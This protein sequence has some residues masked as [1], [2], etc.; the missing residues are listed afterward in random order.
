M[1]AVKMLSL[2]DAAAM[3]ELH[4]IAFPASEAWPLKAFKDLAAQHTTL[5]AGIVI[6][7]DLR[8]MIVAQF[9][10]GEAEILT[11]ATAPAAR[12]CGFAGA[13]LTNLEQ[14]LRSEGLTKWLLD[15]AADNV[16]AIAFYEKQGFEVDGR[17]SNYYKRLEGQRVDA[18]LMSKPVG[19]QITK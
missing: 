4:A 1:T 10:A 2:G 16:G 6:G 3:A 14:R 7:G 9:V 19:G 12:R 15:V 17:R 11:L 8:V 18:I 13:L 5:A